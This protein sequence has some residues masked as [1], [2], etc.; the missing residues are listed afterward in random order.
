MHVAL[1]LAAGTFDGPAFQALPYGFH[2]GFTPID[3]PP[4]ADLTPFDTTTMSSRQYEQGGT[5][6]Q[7]TAQAP[8]RRFQINLSSEPVTGKTYTFTPQGFQPGTETAWAT[9][10]TGEPTT[11]DYCWGTTE[12]TLAIGSVTYAKG[13]E[14]TL[15]ANMGAGAICPGAKGTFS[16]EATGAAPR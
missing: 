2:A 4:G 10:S 15:S 9:Y 7:M 14:F 1:S 16:V 6:Y 8:L 3:A 13:I 5:V 11:W 12:G